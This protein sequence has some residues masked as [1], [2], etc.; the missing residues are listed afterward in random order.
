MPYISGLQNMILDFF[1]G[2]S[3]LIEPH[4]LLTHWSNGDFARRLD[5]LGIPY[6]HSWLG[7]FSRSLQLEHVRMTLHCASKLL[8]LYTDYLRLVRTFN[9][10][11]IYMANYHEL[12]LLW[13]VLKLTRL[14]I[15]CHMADPAPAWPFYKACATLY[16][17]LV[18]RYVAISTSVRERMIA[19][20]IATS[21]ITLLHPGIELSQIPLRRPR[22]DLFTMRYGWPSDAV[23]IGITG[24]ML[25]AKGHEDLIEAA[26]LICAEEPRARFVVGGKLEGRFYQSLNERIT[27]HNITERVVFT[28]WQPNVS[29]FFAGIDIAAVPSRQE[30]GFGLVA[31][32]AM[33]TG[34]PVVATESGGLHDIVQHENNGLFVGKAQARQLAGALLLLIRSPELRGRLGA[35]SRRT[36]EEA[37][38]LRKQVQLLERYLNHCAQSVA[39]LTSSSIE[40]RSS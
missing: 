8:T 17:P 29:D 37:F 35:Q 12:L 39:P 11:I 30:E 28:G 22:T 26:R 10:D 36:V 15:V 9:P 38:D 20:G 33:A 19:L 18:T 40:G 5:K 25:A 27:A 4:F 23:I 32:E 31:I 24:Q 7:F 14:P 3:D 21:K 2:F 34:V 1:G 6:S 16:D 13:P